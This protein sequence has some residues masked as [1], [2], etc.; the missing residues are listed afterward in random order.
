MPIFLLASMALHALLFLIAP[1]LVEGLFPTLERGEQGGVTLITLIDVLPPE[2][3]RAAVS[4]AARMPRSRPQPAPNPEPQQPLRQVT[5]TPASQPAPQAAQ[6][7]QPAPAPSTAPQVRPEPADARPQATATQVESVPTAQ[8][9]PQPERRP[10]P[11]TA[12]LPRPEPAPQARPQ[13]QEPV[14]TSESGVRVAETTPGA[15]ET[16]TAAPADA[17]TAVLGEPAASEVSSGGGERE[18]AESGSGAETDEASSAPSAV[19]APEPALPP[20][21]QSMIASFGGALYPKDAVGLLQRPVTV[22]VAAVVDPD[23]RVIEGVVIEGSGYPYI[24]EYAFNIATR[25]VRYKPYT[26]IYEVSVFITFNPG[27]NSL[28]YRVGDFIKVPPTVGSFAP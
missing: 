8:P 9:S 11:A 1:Q 27:E 4:E 20:T 6:A 21:G 10:S 15:P 22:Q 18:P 3:P 28:T 23:G 5:P 13:V 14:L 12:E 2:Q 16:E 25:A 19:I 17:T 26:D 24:D 7:P